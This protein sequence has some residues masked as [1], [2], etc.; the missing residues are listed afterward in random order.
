MHFVIYAK[1]HLLAAC[2]LD[3]LNTDS[4]VTMH[5]RL[6]MYDSLRCSFFNIKKPP[7]QPKCPVCSESATVD[8][9]EFK[10]R[11]LQDSYRVSQAARGPTSCP[12]KPS[13]KKNGGGDG[14]DDTDNDVPTPYS[15]P[16]IPDFLSISCS[17][18]HNQVRKAGV[19]HVL[20][21]VRS[22]EQFEL[23]HL[24]G[25]INIPLANLSKELPHVQKLSNGVKPVYCICRRGIFS[26][27][28]TLML[29]EKTA[30]SNDKT[31]ETADNLLI[32]SVHNITGGLQSWRQ[33][34][35]TM[36]PKY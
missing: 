7:K 9:G 35:D 5:D 24:K 16:P 2:V 10:I 14:N 21:D 13:K 30:K 3:S 23:C 6:V 32:H 28:A 31:D 8:D 26:T 1:L 33:E 29:H 25:S 27:T 12:L 19:D 36:F 11:S 4:S 17:D 22:K 18:Y 15:L 20:L 34:V